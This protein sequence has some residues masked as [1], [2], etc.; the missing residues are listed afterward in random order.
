MRD[1]SPA[2]LGLALAAVFRKVG[3]KPSHG[4]DTDGVAYEPSLPRGDE[5]ARIEQLLEM[6]GGASWTDADMIGDL[7]GGQTGWS[8]SNQEA[9]DPN[10]VLLRERAQHPDSNIIFHA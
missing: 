6:E 4:P 10:A 8:S 5:K 7:R 1:G 9:E 2:K 3:E